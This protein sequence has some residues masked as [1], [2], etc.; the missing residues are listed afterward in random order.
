M[1]VHKGRGEWKRWKE[2]HDEDSNFQYLNTICLVSP[3]LINL[4]TLLHDQNKSQHL[5]HVCRWK[6]STTQAVLDS[7]FQAFNS[8][9]VAFRIKACMCSGIRTSGGMAPY[10]KGSA[11]GLHS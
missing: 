6:A 4:Y 5:L 11:L 1:V 8:I 3:S 2:R 9:S 10:W 7:H